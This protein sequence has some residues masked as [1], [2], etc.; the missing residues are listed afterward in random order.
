MAWTDQRCYPSRGSGRTT[1][2]LSEEGT[3]FRSRKEYGDHFPSRRWHEACGGA[4]WPELPAARVDGARGREG[5]LFGVPV[6]VEV[7]I[8]GV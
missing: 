2:E 8:G 7:E 5:R 4:D 1:P 3:G 6:V